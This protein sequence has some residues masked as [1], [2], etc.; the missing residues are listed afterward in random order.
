MGC[1]RWGVEG[2][3]SALPCLRSPGTQCL[4]LTLRASAHQQRA[5]TEQCPL[6]LNLAP[7]S[8]LTT[9]YYL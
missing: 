7:G 3:W 1:L 9:P 6:V 5:E 4:R 2:T 8:V